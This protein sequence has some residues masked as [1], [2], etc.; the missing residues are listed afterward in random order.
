MGLDLLN[1][2]RSQLVNHNVLLVIG[3]GTSLLA[4][5]NASTASWK[6][7]LR[8][9]VQRV[10]KLGRSS[11]EALARIAAQIESVDLQEMLSAATFVAKKLGGSE[12]G[13]FRNWLKESIGELRVTNPS[14]IEAIGATEATVLTTNY[15]GLLESVLHLPAI[16][17]KDVDRCEQ[18]LHGGERATIHIHGYWDRADTIIL[19][20]DSYAILNN[21][22]R[23]QTF[24]RAA[25]LSK[26]FVYI[27]C[28][29]GLGD[30]N[31][32]QFLGWSE[33]LF[34][35][36][37]VRRYRLV[38]ETEVETATKMH[39]TRQRV[40]VLSYGK[41]FED[42]IDF[43]K[44]LSPRPGQRMSARAVPASRTLLP[45]I[46]PAPRFELREIDWYEEQ[47][48]A[49]LHGRA[50]DVQHLKQLLAVHPV[51][52]LAGPSGTGKSSL[53]RA[54]LIPEFRKLG[55]RSIVIRPYDDPSSTV[56]G[57]LSRAVLASSSEP[58]VNPITHHAL[59]EQLLPL[60]TAE[61]CPCLVIL[62]DQ[63]EDVLAP[64]AAAH[65]RAWLRGLLTEISRCRET[66][67]FL[68]A[69]V[70]YRTDAEAQ[71]G[72]LWQ[73]ASGNS[74]GFPYHTLLGITVEDAEAVISEVAARLE[75]KL[76]VVPRQ[77]AAELRVESRAAT[78]DAFVFPPYLQILLA[79][80]A[81]ERSKSAVDSA[82][83]SRLGGV[84]GIIASYLRRLLD[85]IEE[86]GGDYQYAHKVL[87]AV[88]RSTGE[89][90]RQSSDEIAENA[91]LT[92]SVTRLLLTELVVKRLVRPLAGDSYEIQHDKLAEVIISELE[93][94]EK[95]AKQAVELL[96]SKS[97]SFEF[98]KALLT[99]GELHL[100]FRHRAK[101]PSKPVAD[102]L[103]ITSVL[104][105]Y[106][107][108]SSPPV[109]WVWFRAKSLKEVLQHLID[110]KFTLRST[111]RKRLNH[112]LTESEIDD[113]DFLTQIA[114]NNVGNLREGALAALEKVNPRRDNERALRK[115]LKH[116]N[117]KLRRAAAFAVRAQ[118]DQRTRTALRKLAISDKSYAVRR[119]AM[120]AF[121][122]ISSPA[123]IEAL[124]V[125]ARRNKG[126][127][128]KEAVDILA[129]NRGAAATRALKSLVHQTPVRTRAARILLQQ[130]KQATGLT[131][132]ILRADDWR[133][134]VILAEESRSLDTLA[135]LAADRAT[136][137]REAALKSIG[138]LGTKAAYDWLVAQ[139]HLGDITPQGA[140]L[141]A[142]AKS[143]YSKALNFLISI[144]ESNLPCANAA[145]D[146]ISEV[147]SV[148]AVT[149]LLEQSTLWQPDADNDSDNEVE[150]DEFDAFGERL[151][152]TRTKP[153]ENPWH[154]DVVAA[155]RALS[156]RG[157]LP[158]LRGWSE[159]RVTRM[160][161]A[162][163]EKYADFSDVA[164]R[165][166]M[167]ALLEKGDDRVKEAVL[168]A[169]AGVV[170]ED[171]QPILKSFDRER[172][173][174]S[175][176]VQS[177]QALKA[178]LYSQ[179]NPRSLPVL[180]ELCVKSKGP[181][182]EYS[183]AVL[184]RFSDP[185]DLPFLIEVVSNMKN[186]A[187]TLVLAALANFD[188]PRA[189][190]TLWQVA[191]G[192]SYDRLNAAVIL[193]QVA[194]DSEKTRRLNECVEQNKFDVA[195]IVD[196]YLN[197]PPWW[198]RD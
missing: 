155:I 9:G 55:W 107:Q 67:P 28:G 72:R 148:E 140:I 5:N 164:D 96:L 184:A 36:S 153:E 128:A 88:C 178:F 52:R 175:D 108:S 26:T 1:D 76:D 188:D 84:R 142:I 168:R 154:R 91:G 62:I 180:R 80:I 38:K 187:R 92:S 99:A 156:S 103:L 56:A 40:Q 183:I 48:A 143:G 70:S 118:T 124:E 32:S 16:T 146:A 54:G 37:Q 100:L 192:R 122:K 157:A 31:F 177:L 59:R 65:A 33:R 120:D 71:L 127:Q 4:T 117:E 194:S 170:L 112:A 57:E 8:D 104:E 18:V 182:R 97:A 163:I 66:T 51:V 109:G 110:A 89:K 95:E 74:A 173:S 35:D 42:L 82:F 196:Y 176:Y 10:R 43:I 119:V 113:L 75:W 190:D 136:S 79:T 73:E 165:A 191:L 85:Q 105:V 101:L 147:G 27:G 86:R 116:E 63:V 131:A 69:V 22:E 93:P 189:R 172:F 24:L 133:L 198:P 90:L 195:G 149:Y 152:K 150:S 61:G 81:S 138:L 121:R 49:Y 161:V 7:L 171:A 34:A 30:P 158:E 114:E 46:S 115:L 29:N 137:V 169:T 2:L 68:K 151:R 39:G 58:F 23:I 174:R 13:E 159:S 53:L 134:K 135:S 126:E 3:A 94:E 19:G 83:I 111:A 12:D 44:N 185:A 78:Q 98:T 181:L 193:C 141:R 167:L 132:Q 123:D 77:L 179:T 14:I 166:W 15:D 47:D 41:Q 145:I 21:D 64:S 50:S 60:L 197:T 11:D 125:I 20:H 160:A 139:L 6:G 144:A 17:W 130:S 25:H 129:A 162:A 186:G 106:Q 45:N 102:R 87:E